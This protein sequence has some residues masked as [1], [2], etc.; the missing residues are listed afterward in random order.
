MLRFNVTIKCDNA[1]F[2]DLPYDD[3]DEVGDPLFREVTR[4]L[5]ELSERTRDGIFSFAE[6]PSIDDPL[7]LRDIDDTIIL[8]DINGNA[9]LV[10]GFS[11]E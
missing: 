11:C 3:A 5:T 10:A 7:I 1:A 8:R 4:L 6:C 9:V 2:H